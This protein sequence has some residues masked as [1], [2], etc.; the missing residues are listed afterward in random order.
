MA[1]VRVP[2]SPTIIRGG[3]TVTRLVQ[4]EFATV[5]HFVAIIIVYVK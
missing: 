1:T 3:A 4:V 5:T 2:M